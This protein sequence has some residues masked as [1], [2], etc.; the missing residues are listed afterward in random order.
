MAARTVCDFRDADGKFFL[1]PSLELRMVENLSGGQFSVVVTPTQDH[2]RAR[3]H[4][5]AWDSKAGH[6]RVTSLRSQKAGGFDVYDHTIVEGAAVDAKYRQVAGVICTNLTLKG[7]QNQ[8]LTPSAPPSATRYDV[9]RKVEGNDGKSQVLRVARRVMLAVPTGSDGKVVT[10]SFAVHTDGTLSRVAGTPVDKLRAEKN[11]SILLPADLLNRVDTRSASSVESPPAV[12]RH[13][14]HF[15]ADGTC[16]AN[17]AAPM[18]LKGRSFTI[19]FWA[20][21]RESN[22]T[23]FVFRQGPYGTRTCLHIGFRANNVFTFAFYADDLNAPPAPA[24][25]KWHHWCCTY[26]H[27]TRMRFIYRDGVEVAKDKAS[28]PYLGHGAPSI[29]RSD[30]H[31]FGGD[32]ADLRVWSSARTVAEVKANLAARLTGREYQL[33]ACWPL[34]AVEDGHVRNLVAQSPKIA[35]RGLYPAHRTITP[36]LRDGNTRAVNFESRTLVAAV[37]RSTF[38]ETVEFKGD[39]SGLEFLYWGKKIG[40]AQ[41]AK[42]PVKA[43]ITNLEGGWKRASARFTVPHGLTHLRAFD[44][45]VLGQWS[46]LELRDHKLQRLSST[47]TQ[48]VYTETLVLPIVAAEHA[49]HVRGRASFELQEQEVARLRQ[50][51]AVREA[52]LNRSPAQ[53]TAAVTQKRNQVTNLRNQAN[54]AT[55]RRAEMERCLTY[56]GVLA[57]RGNNGHNNNYLRVAGQSVHCDAGAVG[58]WEKFVLVNAQNQGSEEAVHYGDWVGLRAHTG[59]FL[60]AGNAS[61]H[62]THYYWLEAEWPHIKSYE[63]FQVLNPDNLNDRGAIASTGGLAFRTNRRDHGLKFVRTSTGGA[64]WN[65]VWCEGATV[66]AGAKWAALRQTYGPGVAKAQSQEAVVRSQLSAAEAELARLEKVAADAANERQRL[67]AERDDY[68]NR[69]T[70]AETQLATAR[71]KLGAQGAASHAMTTLTPDGRKDTVAGAIL[72]FARTFV[73]PEVR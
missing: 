32:L 19:E 43:Q 50:E 26:D 39:A 38:N 65:K 44:L 47:I 33:M 49:S 36:L 37:E 1:A 70:A 6:F 54:Q 57:I 62:H 11:E 24:D 18:D 15:N 58:P 22:R 48:R 4:I 69:R 52:A 16:V 51:H 72:G 73:R 7:P 8:V 28:G 46:K 5:F 40:G 21:R 71:Q 2:E 20:R 29:G 27:D 9:Q 30:Q 31:H 10:V 53:N 42:V 45:R 64:W 56:G 34:L 14:L 17:A 41:T 61:A 67:G 66:D 13:G 59:K 68:R 55:A 12:V 3:W 60:I 35:C 23:A 25:T 63:K